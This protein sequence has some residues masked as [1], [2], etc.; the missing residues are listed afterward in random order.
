M[1][2]IFTRH[3]PVPEC[4]YVAEFVDLKPIDLNQ[5]MDTWDIGATKIVRYERTKTTRALSGCKWVD[6]AIV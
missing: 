4:I 2:K 6:Y 3:D 1:R 5:D